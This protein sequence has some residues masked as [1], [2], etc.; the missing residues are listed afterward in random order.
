[1]ADDASDQHMTDTSTTTTTNNPT[2]ITTNKNHEININLLQSLVKSEFALQSILTRSRPI[3]SLP[4]PK[5]PS[6]VTAILS[7]ARTYSTRTS[8]PAG[9]NPSLQLVRFIG[10]HPLPHQ[11]RTGVLGAMQRTLVADERRAKKRRRMEE[12]E[13]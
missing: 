12:E 1:M 10:P 2:D 11:L 5:T 4:T 9:W 7:L 3:L 13:A 8:A 6:D